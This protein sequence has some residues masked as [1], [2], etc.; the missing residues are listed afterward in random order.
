[1]KDTVARGERVAEVLGRRMPLMERGKGGL[2]KAFPDHWS[3]PGEPGLFAILR[4]PWSGYAGPA[5]RM[6]PACEERLEGGR[7]CDTRT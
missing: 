1:M 6:S 5:L 4:R 2:R 3:L 7:Y